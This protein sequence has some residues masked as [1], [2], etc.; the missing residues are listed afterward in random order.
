MNMATLY[1]IGE[2]GSR[3][4]RWNIDREPVVVGRS[5]MAQVNIQDEGVSRRHF[6]IVR[7][8]EDYVIKD[9]NSRNGT[10]VDGYR[11]LAGKLHDNDWIL[12]GRTLFLF[13]EPLGRSTDVDQPRFGPHGTTIITAASIGKGRSGGRTPQALANNTR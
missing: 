5:G 6:L 12:A 10:W 13:A 11:I 8:G 7:Q 1:E 9:L 4:E 2:D 3:T